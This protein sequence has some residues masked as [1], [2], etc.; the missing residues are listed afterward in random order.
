MSPYEVFVAVP[1]AEVTVYKEMKREVINDSAKTEACLTRPITF[2]I[3]LL[4]VYWLSQ[5]QFC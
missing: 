1:V 2:L 5:Q 4:M 3:I